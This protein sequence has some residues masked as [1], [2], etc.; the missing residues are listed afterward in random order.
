MNRV[1]SETASIATASEPQEPC[2]RI[3]IVEDE[4][5]VA[6]MLARMIADLGDYQIAICVDPT[7]LADFLQNRPDLVLTDLMMPAMDGIQVIERVKQVDPD[8]PVV[9]ISAYATLENAVQAMRA[10]A[11]DFLAKPFRSESIEL[12]L[13]RM[14]RDHILR[15]RAAAAALRAAT[16]DPHLSALRGES[17][18]MQR[19]REWI[20][21]VRD[22]KANVL[23]EGESGTGKE[24]VAT[25]LHGGHGPFVAIN[26][27]AVPEDLA[28]AELFGYRK[29]A[30]TGA[31]RDY[32]GLIMEATG[33]VL[34]LDEVNAT[35]APLQAKLLRC[36]QNRTVRAIGDSREQPADF[37]LISASNQPL[38]QTIQDQGFRR[39][40]YFRL[41]VLHITMPPLRERREDIPGLA[42]HFVRHYARTHERPVRRLSPE[43]ISALLA[44]SWPGN[45]RE[46]ENCIEQAVILCPDGASSLPLEV[47]PHT[48][49]GHGGFGSAEDHSRMPGS[50]LA[51]VERRYILSVLSDCGHNK[52]QA[53]RVLSID[54][55]TLLRKLN[56][57][58]DQG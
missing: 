52:A 3:L 23:I 45:V 17:P 56:A 15:S 20:V 24:L 6:R 10:G 53:A 49:S 33:G 46:L 35:P 21:K 39:D 37:R 30:F 26:M 41:N 7:A 55:K 2:P 48:I 38:E 11:F 29:G 9:V 42:E 12:M 25:A 8:L 50:S 14:R 58:Q 28:E 34:F 4:P 31:A 13:T 47:F 1:R 18:A 44:Y 22:T 32:P 57:W 27:A 43:A 40:L 51:D 16:C 5:D 54:Y 19:V 36:L